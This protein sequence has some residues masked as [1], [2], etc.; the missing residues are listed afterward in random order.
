MV[1]KN[2]PK[3]ATKRIKVRMTVAFTCN[4]TGTVKRKPLVI[5]HSRRPQCF[6][7]VKNLPTDYYSN[8]N[9]WMTSALFEEYLRAWDA[10]LGRKVALL[11]DN[12]TARP[13]HLTSK[14]IELVFL[15]ANTTSLI[16]PLDQGIKKVSRR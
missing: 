10:K 8:S 2:D 3:S 14:N 15:P 11:I 13:K 1:L 7:G 5:D 6:K 12:C 4:M 9:A 16:Q